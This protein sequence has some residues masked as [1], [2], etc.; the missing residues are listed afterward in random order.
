MF[1]KTSIIITLGPATDSPERLGQLID[2]GVNVFRLNMSHAQHDWCRSVVHHIRTIAEEKG[3]HA[4]ILF[5]LQGPSIR[6]GDLESP[7]SLEI[8]DRF[9]IRKQS[10][11]S[12]LPYSTTVNYEGMMD[13]VAEGATLVVDN[14][15][16]LMKIEKKEDDRLICEVLTA[17][18]IGNRRHINLPGTRLNLPALT[19]KDHADLAVAVECKADFIAGSFVRDAAHVN[20]LREEM[21]KLGGT[22]NIVSKVEDQEAIKNIDDIIL[23]SD[24][25]MIA[26]G[27]L[28]IEV[29]VEELPIIQRRITKRCHVLGRRVIVATHMLESMITNPTPTRAEVTDVSTAVYEEADAIMLSGETSVGE[30]PIRCVE[31]LDRIALRM[32]RSGSIGNGELAV[33]ESDKQKVVSAALK[34]ADSIP[35]SEIVVFTRKG[36]MAVQ[37]ALLRPKTNIHAFAPDNES[38]R[39]LALAR[40]IE[41]NTIPFYDD[42]LNTINHA[43]DFMREKDLVAE[44]TPLIVVSDTLRKNKMVD[45]I[46]LIY[47]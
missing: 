29:H 16:M 14:G 45:S 34:L 42:P 12:T 10:A 32:E 38:C 25:I 43:V 28:G 40:G 15:T 1:R 19:E 27:D 20:E 31:T 30:H 23:A 36:V 2:A 18:K 35:D 9:E 33:L 8:G 5:D 13:D 3:K 4:A 26:R 44:G 47:A 6:T 21:E 22:A 11:E 46:L 39:K 7:Y 41:P 24:V 17:G 37:C